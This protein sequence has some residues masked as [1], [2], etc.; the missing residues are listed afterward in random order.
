MVRLRSRWKLQS[1]VGFE[2]GSE[3]NRLGSYSVA[4]VGRSCLELLPCSGTV[5]VA[6]E[7]DIAV[8]G[9]VGLVVEGHIA[10]VGVGI[11]AALASEVDIDSLLEPTAQPKK[12]LVQLERVCLH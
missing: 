8:A 4:G 11:V 5:V 10:V 7:E 6:S 2:S 3:D 9:T 12:F 1:S